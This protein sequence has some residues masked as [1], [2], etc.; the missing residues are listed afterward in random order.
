MATGK[1]DL[2]GLL[3]LHKSIVQ[4]SIHTSA[5]ENDGPPVM[6]AHIQDRKQFSE[7]ALYS[8][9]LHNTVFHNREYILILLR[10]DTIGTGEP[11]ESR[12]NAIFFRK[13]KAGKPE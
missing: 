11:A 2:R 8:L 1:T 3:F 9:Q 12:Y 13:I 7:Y 6:G 5:S 4:V 10:I